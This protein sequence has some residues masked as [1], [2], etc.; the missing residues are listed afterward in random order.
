[1]RRRRKSDNHKVR[2][3]VTESGDPS[4]PVRVVSIRGSLLAPDL[5]SPIDK[6]RT[7]PTCADLFGE[8]LQGIVARIVVWASWTR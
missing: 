8:G 3:R 6:A 2:L 1:M 4:G 7:C 5:L